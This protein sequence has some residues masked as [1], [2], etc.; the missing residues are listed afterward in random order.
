MI[1]RAL[2]S[3]AAAGLITLATAPAA[4]AHD[5][6]VGSIPADGYTVTQLPATAHLVFEEQTA[7]D[8]VTVTVAGQQ[9]PV[10]ASPAD[11]H[12][13][14]VDLSRVRATETVT[15][16]WRAVDE[17]DGHVTTGSVSFHVLE[18]SSAPATLSSPAPTPGFSSIPADGYTVTTL[19]AVARLT[20]P[21][22][23]TPK[24]VTVVVAGRSRP[25]V[26]VPGDPTSVSVDL[27][28]VPATESVTLSWRLT[29]AHPARGAVTFHVLDHVS[30]AGAATSRPSPPFHNLS[31][32]SHV[33][34]Y[35]AMAVLLGGLFFLSVLWPAGAG[36]PRTRRVLVVATLAGGAA[37]TVAVFVAVRQVA[38]LPFREAIAQHF[39]RVSVALALMWLL[40][41]VVVVAVLQSPAAVR[42]PA[43]RVGALVVAIGL[44]RA[45]G[46]SAHATQGN[47]AVVGVLVDFLHLC[48]VSAWVGG[49][50]VLLV[51]VLPRRELAEL[52]LVVPRFS[53]VALVSVGL[54]IT[55]GVVLAVRVV[56]SVDGLFTT[57]YG[58][59]LLVKLTLVGLVLLVGL[60][61]KRWVEQALAQV[62]ALQPGSTVSSFV[63][64][65]AAETFLVIAVLGVASLLVTANPGM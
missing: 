48:A 34:G 10:A 26:A 39:G 56:G 6:L 63:A 3:L 23:V 43:W 46:M 50:V 21:T 4:S 54:V 62:V 8:D 53:R 52:A 58:H 11:P 12:E 16:H 27:A 49:L 45:T 60:L 44:I 13:V 42:R 33:V 65:V 59:V 18:H 57:H 30:S 38:P 61:S 37:A 1:R 31:V 9:L 25:V 32:L 41:V 19:P 47:D 40:A 36:D 51:G 2:L 14:V 7:P 20:F 64:S 22:P 29:G 24:A 28:G 17:H 15:L 35:L 55:S 5:E